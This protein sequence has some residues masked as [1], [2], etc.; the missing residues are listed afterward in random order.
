MPVNLNEAITRIKAAG[1]C[2]VRSVPMAGQD[3]ISGRYQI[4]IRESGTWS[5]V[6]EG[7]TR[8]MAED[9]IRQSTNKVILG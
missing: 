3:V 1:P 5:I 9:I 7:T 2:N 8:S 4:E 6:L